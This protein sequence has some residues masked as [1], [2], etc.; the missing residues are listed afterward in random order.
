[1]S[2]KVELRDFV[3]KHYQLIAT[4]GVFGA[5]TALFIRLE[6]FENVAFI[7]LMIF[8]V[9]MWE[10]I[11]SFPEIEIPLRSSVKLVIFEFLMIIFLM[12]VGWF[13]FVE[14]VSMHYKIFALVLFLGIYSLVTLKI[15]GKFRLFERIRNKVKGEPYGFIRFILLLVIVGIILVLASYSA[16]FIIDL[17]ESTMT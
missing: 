1:M 2:N 3:E 4:I 11:D 8:F 15:L 14:Y 12:V 13:I 17:I 5:I 7:P 10:L 16:N 9:L 6:G